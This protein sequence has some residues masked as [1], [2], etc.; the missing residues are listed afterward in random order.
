M[1]GELFDRSKEEDRLEV[2]SN[3]STKKAWDDRWE[4]EKRP[5]SQSFDGVFA[6]L[7]S[8]SQKKKGG[9]K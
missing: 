5:R 3:E 7:P 4:L 1:K 2:S 6:L 8:G 9:V